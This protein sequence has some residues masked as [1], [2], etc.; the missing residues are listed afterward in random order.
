MESQTVYQFYPHD[1]PIERELDQIE[2]VIRQ[3]WSITFI[4]KWVD[5]SHINFVV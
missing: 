4:Y 5:I 1:P 2:K 3:S